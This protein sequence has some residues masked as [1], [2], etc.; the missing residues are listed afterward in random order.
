MTI[1]DHRERTRMLAG[2]VGLT[3]DDAERAALADA[4]CGLIDIIDEACAGFGAD[5]PEP[6]ARP[7][8]TRWP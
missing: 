5:A 2:A 7:G 4:L 8:A 3:L 6:L 1:G